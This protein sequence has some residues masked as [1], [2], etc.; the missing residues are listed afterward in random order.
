MLQLAVRLSRLLL[1]APALLAAPPLLHA[2]QAA[3]PVEQSAR[4][5]L[6]RQGAGLPGQVEIEVGKLDP[7]NRLPPCAELEA[8][9]PTGVRAWG[10]INVG[11]RCASP[12]NWTVYLPAHVRV[13]TD[14]VVTREAL[15]RGQIIGPGDIG[16]ERGD[17][18][19]LPDNTL[20]DPSRAIGVHAAQSVAAGQPLR[21][22]MLRLPPAVE[23]GQTVRVVGS[24]S[25]FSVSGEGRALNRAGDGESVRVRL[26]NG[27]IVTGIAR[28]G[29]IVEMR[30]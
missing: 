23:R 1:L 18:T 28:A 20:T 19:A 22:D 17:L 3:E 7:A 6:E 4:A 13:V 24:G 21:V 5:L 11:V 12:V 15:R 30:F 14:Y 16:T 9:L 27:Q 26:A 8:F 10:R 25:G 29:G 2:G